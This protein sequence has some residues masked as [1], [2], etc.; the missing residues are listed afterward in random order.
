[1]N[2]QTLSSVALGLAL[3][4]GV[5]AFTTPQPAAAQWVVFDPTNYVQ[6]FLT[7][8]RAVQSNVNEAQ[9]IA[10]QLQQLR[11]MAQNT[12][13]L[14]GGSWNQ[15][16][17]ALSRL[18][19][20]LNEGRALA[21]SAKYYDQASKSRFPGYEPQRDYS[22]SYREWN[23][24]TRDSV[25]SAMRVANMQVTGMRNETQMLASLRSAAAS[26]GGQKAAIDA[27]NQIA[28]AQI[29]QLQQLRELMVAQMQ[30]QSTYMASEAQAEAA[31]STS[32]REASRYRDPRQGWKP[33][34]IEVK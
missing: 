13:G 14:T 4:L 25:L 27:G 7:Q 3:A 11:N 6:S 15:A 8:L 32:I 12:E 2:K 21:A 17:D 22:A 20:L 18:D 33:K 28:L 23:Q 29:N 34:P 19:A 31:K 26:T 16:N 24:T 1:M 9:Q 10:N 30:A 5:A